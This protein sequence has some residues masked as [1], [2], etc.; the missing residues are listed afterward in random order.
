MRDRGLGF[1]RPRPEQ[2]G[3]TFERR[4]TSRRLMDEVS[5]APMEQGRE[6]WSDG[7]SDDE[8]QFR[9]EVEANTQDGELYE[10]LDG[11][12]ERWL[13]RA[14]ERG[15]AFESAM[16]ILDSIA[17]LDPPEEGYGEGFDE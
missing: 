3:P 14:K 10:G 13:K 4:D 1:A 7:L 16:R 15:L 8:R 9:D 6:G 11:W 5:G 17:D 12:Q 2:N